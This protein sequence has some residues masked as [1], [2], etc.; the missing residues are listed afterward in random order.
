[1]SKISIAQ[2]AQNIRIE[3]DVK[4]GNSKNTSTE[5]SHNYTETNIGIFKMK[6]T[7]LN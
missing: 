7:K 5:L 6:F 1:M 4:T 3:D 2:D